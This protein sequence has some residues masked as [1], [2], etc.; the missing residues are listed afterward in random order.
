MKKKTLFFASLYLFMSSCSDLKVPRPIY[1]C[2]VVD[3]SNIKWDQGKAIINMD[4][5]SQYYTFLNYEKSDHAYHYFKFGVLSQN[6]KPFLFDPKNIFFTTSNLNE[7]PKSYPIIDPED[8]ILKMRYNNELMATEAENE[9]IRAKN[10][11]TAIIL[12]S[13]GVA[14]TAATISS[15]D[16][17][18]SNS[19][20]T[21]TT[22]SDYRNKNYPC[23]YN[24]SIP[25]YEIRAM[26]NNKNLTLEQIK[27]NEELQHENNNKLLRK[28]TLFKDQVNEG[29]FLVPIVSTN[30]NTF[31]ITIP[32][33]DKK[34]G[35]YVFKQ[36]IYTPATP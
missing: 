19:N 23:N 25:L 15:M 20:P 8:M 35:Q 16:R 1:Y 6:E 26:E 10:A 30:F 27:I 14:L 32:I 28:T 3:S 12:T 21:K 11:N 7:E 29:I 13:L 17:N 2:E 31:C 18:K 5:D 24:Y 34:Y 22:S 33:D 4:F 36:K 9:V